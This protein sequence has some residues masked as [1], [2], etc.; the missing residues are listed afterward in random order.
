MFLEIKG[1]FIIMG[2]VMISIVIGLIMPV[3]FFLAFLLIMGVMFYVLG[4]VILYAKLI[5]T[6]A[7]RVMEPNKPDQEKCILFDLSHNITFQR[8]NKKEEGK[9]EFVRYGKEAAIINRG[10]YPI[11]FP[12][13]DRGFVGHESYDLDV[14]LYETEALDKLPGDDIKEI[15]YKRMEEVSK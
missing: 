14:D 1:M 7:N 5:S 8:V 15:Y 10:R 12:N 13:G 4:D 9:R 3:N 6:Q 2:L 11:R